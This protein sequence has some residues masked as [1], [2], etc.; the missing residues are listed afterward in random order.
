MRQEAI[1]LKDDQGHIYKML[2]MSVD[3][4]ENETAPHMLQTTEKNYLS[5]LQNIHGLIVFVLDEN[6]SLVFMHGDV[7]EI[8]G[9]TKE[10]FLSENVKWTEI[11]VPE[12]QS[13]EEKREKTTPPSSPAAAKWVQGKALGGVQGRGPCRGLGWPPSPPRRSAPAVSERTA[14]QAL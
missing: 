8:T 6:F 11:I 10:D 7:E 12:N 4:T 9:Y 13:I 2:G 1:F 14:P 3:E 5:F